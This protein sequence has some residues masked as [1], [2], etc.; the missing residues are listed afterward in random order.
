MQLADRYG[1]LSTFTACNYAFTQQINNIKLVKE[2]LRIVMG[3]FDHNSKI[4]NTSL[5]SQLKRKKYV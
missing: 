3:Y 2:C 1:K 4:Y 5:S